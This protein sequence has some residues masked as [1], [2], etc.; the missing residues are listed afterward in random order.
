MIPV[1]AEE[2]MIRRSFYFWNLSEKTRMKMQQSEKEEEID[3]AGK[4]I[5]KCEIDVAF[6]TINS[7]ETIKI[8]AKGIF[9]CVT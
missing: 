2:K 7:T 9:R 3:Q 8:T 6:D 1:Y 4:I 5:C